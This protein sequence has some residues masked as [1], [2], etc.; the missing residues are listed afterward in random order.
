MNTQFE[1]VRDA[2]KASWNKFSPGW[3]KW[4]DLTMSFLQPHGD[5][6]I[7]HLKPG[8]SDIILD[9]AAGT[10]EP[11]LTMA[12]MLSGGKVILTDL[13]EGMLA[14][15]RE[16][17][18]V[19]GIDNIEIQIADACELPYQ[20]N[21]FDA[22]SCRLGFMFF[23]DMH[24]AAAEMVRVLK[25]GGRLATTVWGPA[26]QNFWVTCISQNIKKYIDMPT[27]QEGAPGMFRCARQGLL[28]GIF[29]NLGLVDIA[30][31]EI[32][33]KI[34]CS[35]AEEY[36]NFMTEIAAPFV[37]ALSTADD[38]TVAKIKDGVIEAIDERYP[39]ETSIDTSGILIYGEKASLL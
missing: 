31:A 15:S 20:N 26:E 19:A 8:G 10:G 22:V 30:E 37:G 14:V 4:D 35:S 7:Q 3:K 39:N 24:Q 21:S 25:P 28:S 2:Q 6:I 27:P 16:K 36:W 5:A 34:N 1:T 17:A 29:E 12:S 23:P 9:I 38:Q 11:G 13:S 33:G 32:P 18:D